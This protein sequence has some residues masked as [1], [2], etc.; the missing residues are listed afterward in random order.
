MPFGEHR[1]ARASIRMPVDK[2]QSAT[3]GSTEL[4][5]TK[6]RSKHFGA[7]AARQMLRRA[8][9]G[10][11]QTTWRAGSGPTEAAQA[12]RRDGEKGEAR[13]F[14]LNIAASLVALKGTD[15]VV[16]SFSYLQIVKRPPT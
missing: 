15:T 12:G 10:C 6:N 5:A 13:R 11:A 9:E 2:M 14:A 7:R 16:E 8:E 4:A 1:E 3:Q